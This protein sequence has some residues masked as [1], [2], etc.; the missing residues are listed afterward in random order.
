MSPHVGD[1]GVLDE[2][3]PF[4]EGAAGQA[5]GRILLRFAQV[6]PTNGHALRALRPRHRPRLAIRRSWPAADGLRRLERRHEP[7]R[8]Q[9]KG[10][11]VW[12]GFFLYDVLMQFAELAR[13]VD[14][15]R[16]RRTL[17]ELGRAAEEYRT[18]MPGTANGIGA[19]ISTMARR[20]AR[21]TTRNARSI[22]SR[23]AGR[24]SRGAGDPERSTSGHGMRRSA[25]LFAAT[26]V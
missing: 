6:V 4:L 14:D 5:G 22:R 8:Q 10:E 16:L 12:L 1:T 23:K 13:C 19:P 2:H 26:H 11:S 18:N 3:V 15:T 21:Q 7:G 20:S 25:A 9:G 24:S 17:L